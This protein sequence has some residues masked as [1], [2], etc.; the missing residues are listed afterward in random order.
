M[1]KIEI[2][3][4]ILAADMGNLEAGIR[5]CEKSGADQIHVDVMDGVFVPN[6]SMGPAVAAMADRVTDL[7]LDVHL[8]LLHPQN[9]IEAFAKAGSDTILIHIEAE[10]DVEDT[11]KKIR[12]LGCRP[13][14]TVNPPTPVDSIFQTLEKGLVEEVLIMSVNPG[15]G[16][17]GYIAG[18]E[19]KVAEIRRRYPDMLISIDG[20]IGAETIKP[21]AAHGANLFV[22]G[23]SLFKAPDMGKAVSDL[24][25]SAETAYCTAL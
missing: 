20:G 7:P 11:L 12:D 25:A 1:P 10:C 6:I 15:F 4:S 8:M 18:V 16:G 17:Q 5:L 9:H 22:A 24:R 14:I 19:S 21:A 2:M 13:G 3:P 23:T